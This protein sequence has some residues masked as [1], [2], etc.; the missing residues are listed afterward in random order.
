VYFGKEIYL[1]IL[2]AFAGIPDLLWVC[3]QTEFS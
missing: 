3:I 2:K 1:G